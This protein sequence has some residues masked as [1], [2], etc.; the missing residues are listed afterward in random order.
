MIHSL[1]AIDA[2][3]VATVV[4]AT[5]VVVVVV[6]CFELLMRRVLHVDFAALK[7]RRTRFVVGER[8][9]RRLEQLELHERLTF[10]LHDKHCLQ[11]TKRS[12]QCC[13]VCVEDVVW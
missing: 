1:I 7:V 13:H 12:K 9:T 10:V 4:V 6:R 11:L 5:V 8:C 2:T 3:T